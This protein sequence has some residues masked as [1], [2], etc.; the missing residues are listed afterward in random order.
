MPHCPIHSTAVLDEL[1][2]VELVD[3]DDEPVLESLGNVPIAVI[4]NDVLVAVHGSICRYLPTK[5]TQHS[6]G[7]EI[8]IDIIRMIAIGITCCWY[9]WH[10]HM[11]R[12]DTCN[13]LQPLL[14]MG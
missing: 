9:Y 12:D 2:E 6:E 14:L 5:S 10:H 1:E 8:A 3:D 7:R 11:E 4:A 13:R